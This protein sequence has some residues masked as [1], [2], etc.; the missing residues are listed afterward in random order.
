MDKVNG[1]GGHSAVIRTFP[2][3][4]LNRCVSAGASPRP[5]GNSP[6]ATSDIRR[7]LGDIA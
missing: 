4:S 3:G 5:S 6:T 2:F 1:D 7:T